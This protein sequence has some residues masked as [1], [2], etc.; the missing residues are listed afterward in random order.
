MKRSLRSVMGVVFGALD[1][2]VAYSPPLEH[3]VLPQ[4]KD[5]VEAIRRVLEY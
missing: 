2:P 4:L 5:V 3:A 1:A